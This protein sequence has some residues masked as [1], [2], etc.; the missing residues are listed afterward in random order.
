MGS[1]SGG[2][3]LC[4]AFDKVA[5]DGL[6]KQESL[7]HSSHACQAIVELALE[8]LVNGD[9]GIGHL[10]NAASRVERLPLQNPDDFIGQRYPFL[11]PERV[12]E[13][14]HDEPRIIPLAYQK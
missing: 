12:E 1:K 6:V 14:E 5:Q 10:W 9:G 13:R 7:T 11:W 8:Q 2:K 4:Q 3:E